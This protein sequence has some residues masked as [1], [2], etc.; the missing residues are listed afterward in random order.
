MR[1]GRGGGDIAKKGRI[2]WIGG[3]HISIFGG[4]ECI[5]KKEKL[6]KKGISLRWLRGGRK[7]CLYSE[8]RFSLFIPLKKGECPME[9]KIKFRQEGG[10]FCM[11]GKICPREKGAGRKYAIWESKSDVIGRKG[12]GKLP[13]LKRKRIE[14]IKLRGEK[15]KGDHYRR[16]GLRTI[17]PQ[18]RKGEQ[19][20]CS[21]EKK[22]S[23]G[24]KSRAQ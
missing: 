2:P 11:R 9:G 19:K 15:K 18:L 17:V 1:G 8:K 22:G 13:R 21:R 6:S 16:E 7:L 12:Q 14:E 10:S 24:E 20:R 23:R 4:G 3:D 5:L